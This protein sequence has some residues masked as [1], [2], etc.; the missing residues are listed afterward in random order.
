M[1]SLDTE[2]KN[3]IISFLRSA[4]N[5]TSASD[6]AK[7][8]GHNRITVG[9]YLQVLEAQNLV[10]SKKIASGIYW[11]LSN[12]VTKPKILIV[13]DE[14]HIV[15]LIRLSLSSDN[16]ILYEAYDGEEA[17]NTAITII[18]DLI[19]LDLMM[20]KKSGIEVCKAIKK[21]FLTQDVIVVIVSAKGQIQDKVLLIEQGAD[22]YIV[23]PFDPL[24]LEARV[25][26][27]LRKKQTQH[28]TNPLT[29]LPNAS[30]TAEQR[31]IFKKT[32]THWYETTISI[33]YYDLFVEYF[34]YTRARQTLRLIVKT[35]IE[36]I[37]NFSSDY[38][39]GH[40]VDTSIVIFSTVSLKK[41]FPKI[42]NLFLSLL[43]FFY[44]DLVLEE[45]SVIVKKG[46]RQISISTLALE[47]S[48]EKHE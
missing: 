3:K 31:K 29:L 42:Q 23:K 26:N 46:T 22:D 35:I 4:G 24:E 14:K 12:S 5:E 45:S 30:I 19:I 17:L 39:I 21:N 34:G 33:L 1:S 40:T 16:Y 28:M 20:P 25:S 38:F 18:P 8:I 27:L 43:P 10:I 37:P 6:I 9:K 41:G 15:D 36:Q 48:E 7:K 2:I 47:L 32:H 13:D 44:P 11:K